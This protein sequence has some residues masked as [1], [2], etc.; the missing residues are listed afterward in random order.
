V[1]IFG[2]FFMNAS[3]LGVAINSSIAFANFGFF[4]F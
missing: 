2:W 3:D 1:V 4:F